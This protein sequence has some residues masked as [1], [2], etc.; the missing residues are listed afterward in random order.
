M[1]PF[2]VE[3]GGRVEVEEWSRMWIKHRE[4]VSR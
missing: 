4:K 3:M 1:F 2:T